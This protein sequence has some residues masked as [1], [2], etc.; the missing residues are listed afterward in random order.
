MKKN[1]NDFNWKVFFVTAIIAA[2]FM[3]SA[4]IAQKQ[5]HIS[6][7]AGDLLPKLTPWAGIGG[8]GAGGSGGGGAAAKWVGKGVTGGLVDVQILY[9]NSIGQNFFNYSLTPRFSMKPRWSTTVAVQMPILSKIGEVQPTTL[10]EPEYAITGGYGDLG[11][12]VTQSFG[13]EGQYSFGLALTLPTGQYDIKRGSDAGKT[14]LPTSLQK[15]T[16]LYN[17]SLLLGFIKDTEK[18]IWLF[19]LT[20]S[21]P[22]NMK[23]FSQENEFMDKYFTKYKSY[24]DSA[25][26]DIQDRFYYTFKPYGENDLGGYT[27]PSVNLSVYYGYKEVEGWMHS[28]GITFNVP[29]GVAWVPNEVTP[30]NESEM[31]YNPRKDPDHQAWSATLNYGV[32]VGDHKYPWF[33][34]LGLPIHDLAKSTYEQWDRPDWSDFFNQWTITVGVKSTMF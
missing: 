7:A 11:L 15:G 30:A 26:S 12:D 5:K 34:A 19:D 33:F 16:G 32:E 24:E 6:Q 4:F 1:S 27:P 10:Y 22:F 20:Y 9:S 31:I 17:A 14:I 23:L 2:S 29:F 13:M 18:G 3:L 28:W 21:H 8:C 25:E